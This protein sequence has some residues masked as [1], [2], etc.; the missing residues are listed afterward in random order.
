MKYSIIFTFFFV[1]LCY[2]N[3]LSPCIQKCLEPM[4]KIEK[5]ISYIYRNYENVCDILEKQA[6]CAQDCSATDRAIF[7]QY[8]TFYRIHCVDMEEELE[9]HMP[10]LK[11][12]SYKADFVCR[13]KC[14]HKPQ[15]NMNK[16]EKQKNICKT[17]ECS[18]M[19]YFKQFSESCPK[20]QN[21]ML[22]LNVR[23]AEEMRRLTHEKHVQ[24]MNEQCRRIHDGEYIRSQLLEAI[25]HEKVAKLDKMD[26]KT[27]KE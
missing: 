10:C 6:L 12:A 14:Q 19:C 27:K 2:A 3:D 20:A 16:E 9:E 18:T 1:S 8:T 5:T 15:K 7:F 21:V 17:V 24:D 4:T 25:K 26:K 13:D 23:N 22:K 11:E